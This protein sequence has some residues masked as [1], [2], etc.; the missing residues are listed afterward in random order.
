METRD[1]GGFLELHVRV[2]VDVRLSGLSAAESQSAARAIGPRDD[3][4]VMP[5]GIAPVDSSSA[6]VPVDLAFAPSRRIRPVVE[7]ALLDAPEDLVELGLAHQ[8]SVVLDDD[9]VILGCNEI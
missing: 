7:P 1:S 8:E 4:K 2:S 6:I 3:L 5:V 9:L